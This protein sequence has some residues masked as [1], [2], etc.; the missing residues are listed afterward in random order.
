MHD[1]TLALALTLTHAVLVYVTCVAH[2][3]SF[4][5]PPHIMSLMPLPTSPGCEAARGRGTAG[6]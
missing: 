4:V 2:D 3:Q 5:F 6:G 1:L